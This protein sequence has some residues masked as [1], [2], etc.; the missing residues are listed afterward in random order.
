MTVRRVADLTDGVVDQFKPG[1]VKSGLTGDDLVWVMENKER[2]D[3]WVKTLQDNRD[4]DVE[5]QAKREKE[6]RKFFREL[7]GTPDEQIVHAKAWNIE[8]GWCFTEDDF[9]NLGPA[10]TVPNEKLVPIVLEVSLD[11]ISETIEALWP[12]IARQQPAKWRWEK[13]F[14]DAKSLALISGQTHVRGLRWRVLDLKAN[15]DG[16]TGVSTQNARLKAGNNSLFP[17]ADLLSAAAHFPKWIAAMDGVRVPYVW[18]GGY[19]LTV[20]GRDPLV[21]VLNRDV[22]DGTVNFDAGNLDCPYSNYAVPLRREPV[23]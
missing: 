23:R 8:S 21:P 22:D 19:D 2:L 14:S 12:I 11:T 17:H 15:W 16:K 3:W 9:A 5:E 20:R 18:V 1:L 6:E 13:L 4:T 10:P 7:F